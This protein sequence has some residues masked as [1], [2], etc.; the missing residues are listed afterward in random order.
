MYYVVLNDYQNKRTLFF[1]T[2]PYIYLIQYKYMFTL[3]TKSN[4]LY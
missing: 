4:F 2:F 1:T 3:T